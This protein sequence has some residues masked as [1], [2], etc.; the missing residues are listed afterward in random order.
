MKLPIAVRG[1]DVLF[2]SSPVRSVPEMLPSKRQV[3]KVE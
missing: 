3:D 2:V 1:S